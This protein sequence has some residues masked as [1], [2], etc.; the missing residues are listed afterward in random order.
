MTKLSSTKRILFKS[1]AKLI[2]GVATVASLLSVASVNAVSLSGVGDW[3]TPYA[4][5][6]EAGNHEKN[7]A[8]QLSDL[9]L[10]YDCE[11]QTLHAL[12]LT[13]DGVFAG[14]SPS[15]AYIK[16]FDSTGDGVYSNDGKI[17]GGGGVGS[18]FDWVT[19]GDKTV[20]WI[21]SSDSGLVIPEGSLINA[22]I[23]VG[24]DGESSAG[25]TSATS[26]PGG[27][28]NRQIPLV[29]NC[30]GNPPPPP[31]AQTYTISGS[32]SL[33][34]A[35][36][37]DA[38]VGFGGVL[39]N[40]SGAASGT[41]TTDSNGAY[42]F[43]GLSAGTYSITVVNSDPSTYY[44]APGSSET[45]SVSVSTADV[46]AATVQ[47]NEFLSV[48]GAVEIL[49]LG[50]NTVSPFAGVTVDLVGSDDSGA[51]VVLTA[52]TDDSGA[53][54]FG[55]LRQAGVDGYTLLY[56]V[57]ADA[58]ATKSLSGSCNASDSVVYEF[59]PN[60]VLNCVVDGSCTGV[61]RTI[62]FWKAQLSGRKGKGNNLSDVMPDLLAAVETLALDN[63]YV[64]SPAP[65]GTV[66]ATGVAQALA[67]I[68]D[69]NNSSPYVKLLKQ[70]LASELNSVTPGIGGLEN[71][72]LESALF[73]WGEYIYAN[74]ASEEELLLAKNI[75]DAMNNMGH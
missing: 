18:H 14:Q 15:D 48:N 2:A 24:L 53:Y 22:H 65:E 8:I 59:D 43:S 66:D 63:P 20:G 25:R 12:I 32:V 19:D 34:A 40:L 30:T 70:M 33:D 42:A 74:G 6:W 49:V 31:P 13:R 68:D 72:L 56:S 9:Y 45:Q 41:S 23:Q 5:M 71:N 61:G 29:V 64:F 16:L 11:S 26:G 39:V 54:A 3:G 73:N 46:E 51:D 50:V 21:G 47:F 17:I 7:N 60:G 27:A 62:G 28:S 57:G 10:K 44:V 38:P 55:G 75:F 35:T 1:T 69:K 67:I 36:C 4:T 58:L 52:T 37:D